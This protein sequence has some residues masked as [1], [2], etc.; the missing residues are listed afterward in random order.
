MKPNLEVETLHIV[1]VMKRLNDISWKS[2]PEKPLDC[3]EYSDKVFKIFKDYACNKRQ[4][5]YVVFVR[6]DVEK[7]MLHSYEWMHNAEKPHSYLHDIY[8]S[9]WMPCIQHIMNMLTKSI[10]QTHQGFLMHEE[11]NGEMKRY[12]LNPINVVGEKPEQIYYVC[13]D[14]HVMDIKDVSSYKSEF[15][16]LFKKINTKN[17]FK[18]IIIHELGHIFLNH[19]ERIKGKPT[20][21]DRIDLDYE[22][23]LWSLLSMITNNWSSIAA[24]QILYHHFF[25]FKDHCPYAQLQGNLKTQYLKSLYNHKKQEKLFKSKYKKRENLTQIFDLEVA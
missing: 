12:D 9:D 3:I 17:L 7:L 8:E 18:K 20:L 10:A 24:I 19:F 6:Y 23:N 2:G 13:F 5:Y 21:K 22:A 1:D 25:S 14:K 15:L 4:E 11:E 16:P